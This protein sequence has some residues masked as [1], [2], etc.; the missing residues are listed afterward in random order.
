M[1]P[2]RKIANLLIEVWKPA[3]FTAL[4]NTFSNRKPLKIKKGDSILHQGDQP[5]RLYFVK[6][7]YVKL[8]RLL[9]DGKDPIVY[10][11]GPGSMIG[12]RAL[13]S[14]DRELKHNAQALTDVEIVS[15][16][17]QDYIE[18]VSKYPE[19]LV[20]LLSVFIDRLNYSE[21]KIEGF[22]T[23]N[24]TTRVA[25]F[26]S[27]VANRFG[28]KRGKIITLPIPLTHQQVAEFVGS[29]RE[30]VTIAISKL[31]KE[32]IIKNERGKIAIL[33][34]NKLNSYFKP[35]SSL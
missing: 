19:Y 9:E 4:F 11:C 33:N 25:N 1:E 3:D 15:I 34:L 6:S 5:D 14:Q 27:Y 21:Q 12:I 28:N 18:I 13:T 10:L 30:T 35:K 22:V 20:D 23:T 31:E 8:Y 16:P 29:A 26:L 7:G 24:A 17:R 2:N 32:K